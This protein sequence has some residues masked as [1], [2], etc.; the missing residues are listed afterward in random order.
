MSQCGPCGR[1]MPRW[2]GGGT[3]RIIACIDGRRTWQ[4][5]NCLGESA[6]VA[7]RTEQWIGSDNVRTGAAILGS[8]LR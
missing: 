7:G 5:W 4:N 1:V 6:M 8:R 2:I 3:D